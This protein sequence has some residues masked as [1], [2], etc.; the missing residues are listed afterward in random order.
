MC[1]VA[2]N[3]SWWYKPRPWTDH[4]GGNFRF[5]CAKGDSYLL[6][7]TSSWAPRYCEAN[8]D[9]FSASQPGSAF[10]F[11]LLNTCPVNNADLTTKVYLSE[12]YR[13]INYSPVP[14][15]K[16][17]QIAWWE[18][19]S[20]VSV[21]NVLKSRMFYKVYEDQ[22]QYAAALTYLQ[23]HQPQ[24]NLYVPSYEPTSG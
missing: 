7:R 22:R 14:K 1:A 11:K 19:I 9:R 12:V 8:Q 3:T 23:T 5:H 20:V 4:L 13:R 15:K 24:K 2:E 17:D 10:V 16:Y 21:E 6:V 18:C